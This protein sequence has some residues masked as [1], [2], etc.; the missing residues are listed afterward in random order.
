[1]G[2]TVTDGTGF[3][4][5]FVVAGVFVVVDGFSV[6]GDFI[7]VGGTSVVGGTAVVGALDAIG[8]IGVVKS[9]S[10][11]Y[12]GAVAFTPG[13]T[14][15]SIQSTNLATLV[16]TPGKPGSAQPTPNDVTPTT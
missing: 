5:G 12:T 1:M 9:S 10:G 11:T 16:Y 4:G 13:Q 2:A 8:D 6:V 3:V 15:L 14:T 7:G